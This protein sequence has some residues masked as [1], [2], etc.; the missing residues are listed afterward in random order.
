MWSSSLQVW[1]DC[2]VVVSGGGRDQA[3]SLGLPCLEAESLISECELQAGIRDG[4]LRG[5][6]TH[7]V[8]PH[9]GLSGPSL[10][11][12]QGL[13]CHLSSR[14]SEFAS[15]RE[16]TSLSD[17]G[18]PG[19]EELGTQLVRA[20]RNGVQALRKSFLGSLLARHSRIYG[21]DLIQ[22]PSGPLGLVIGT[23]PP[24]ISSPA[25]CLCVWLG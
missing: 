16:C 8:K 10:A 5:L 12:G 25:P 3:W 14:K 24:I 7:P 11:V 2:A 22:L 9:K 23:A 18:S 19:I 17:P 20:I 21:W 1:G 15:R 13:K 4:F 6:W